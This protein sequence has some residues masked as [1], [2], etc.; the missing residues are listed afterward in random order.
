MIP[1]PSRTN[2]AW[3]LNNAQSKEALYFCHSHDYPLQWKKTS[4]RLHYTLVARSCHRHLREG[5]WLAWP[6]AWGKGSP[7]ILNSRLN[8]FSAQVSWNTYLEAHAGNVVMIKTSRFQSSSVSFTL[9]QNSIKRHML[10]FE[11]ASYKHQ[12]QGSCKNLPVPSSEA[13]V[14]GETL[15]WPHRL[16]DVDIRQSSLQA[17]AALLWRD[18]FC[19]HVGLVWISSRLWHCFR[20]PIISMVTD[21]R[22]SWSLLRE[23]CEVE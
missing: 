3:T 10:P 19:L 20:H 12:S 2:L 9:W 22:C 23:T 16:P 17:L 8:L 4:L 1:S 14:C 11:V 7:K 15:K 6:R 21:S 18:R 13:E 5:W